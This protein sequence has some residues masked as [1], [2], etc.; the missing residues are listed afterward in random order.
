MLEPAPSLF[1]RVTA[2]FSRQRA[3]RPDERDLMPAAAEAGAT[4]PV[5][6]PDEESSY[7]I[8]A[9]LRR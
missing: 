9:F 3:E 2:T 4:A 7:D 8:P 5:A 1:A 6:A